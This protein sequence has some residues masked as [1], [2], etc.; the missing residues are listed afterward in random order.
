MAA[1][2]E[3]EV[4]PRWML[5]VGPT[6][7]AEAGESQTEAEAIGEHGSADEMGSDSLCSLIKEGLIPRA[8]PRVRKVQLVRLRP[9]QKLWVR[10]VA[11]ASALTAPLRSN[12]MDTFA[13]TK[14]YSC[15]LSYL[16]C[17][18]LFLLACFLI[19]L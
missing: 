15:V 8:K 14:T 19:H 3:A 11:P 9:R 18:S 17:V 5:S 16:C 6:S 10:K 7:P 4:P 13:D 2:H 12:I 1:T